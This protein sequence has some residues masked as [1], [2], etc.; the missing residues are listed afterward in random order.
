MSFL[1]RRNCSKCYSLRYKIKKIVFTFLVDSY[2]NQ[3]MCYIYMSKV[4]II[5]LNIDIKIKG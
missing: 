2:N 3:Y 1:Q 5:Y 4:I